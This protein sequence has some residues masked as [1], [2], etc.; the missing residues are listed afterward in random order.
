M[1]AAVPRFDP[2]VPRGLIGLL[3]AIAFGAFAGQLAL[4]DTTDF[5][6]GR[7]AFAGGAVAGLVA[8]VAVAVAFVESETPL[9]EDGFA[10]RV[11]PA[12]TALVSL[13]LMSP[14]AFVLCLAI[15]R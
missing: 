7:V 13:S 6:A 11:R 5:T 10:R 2:D 3:V 1:I 8:L 9:A 14:V 12:L 4:R 15:R